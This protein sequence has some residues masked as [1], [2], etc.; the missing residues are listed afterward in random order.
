VQ[1][2]WRDIIVIDKGPLY[3]TGGSTSHAPGLVFQ[4]NF[5]KVMTEFAKYTV[6]LFWGRTFD[7]NPAWYP[8][9]GIEVAYTPE[10]LEDLKRKHGA[11]TS[12]N[13]E[14]LSRR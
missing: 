10:Q 9:G 2:G 5:S 7:G 13:L 14:S 4:T 12:Y 8:V 1:K 3:E 11:A 6:S